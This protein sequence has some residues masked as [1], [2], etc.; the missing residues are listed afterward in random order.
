MARKDVDK[1]I[2]E[3][4]IDKKE[5][6][7]KVAATFI[8]YATYIIIFFGFLWFLINYVFPMFGGGAA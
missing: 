3:R 4:H 5:D 2:E 7:S 6:N 8:K 1:E